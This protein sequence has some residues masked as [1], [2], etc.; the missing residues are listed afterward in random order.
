MTSSCRVRRALETA[1]AGRGSYPRWCS[2]PGGLHLRPSWWY[3]SRQQL[4]A[5]GPGF[6][7]GLVPVRSP[8]RKESY[9]VSFPPL[10]YM[11]KFS[12][13]ADL[14]SCLR[15][16]EANYIGG[17]LQA[18]RT[19][20]SGNGGRNNSNNCRNGNKNKSKN[21]GSTTA[22]TATATATTQTTTTTT[23]TA[24]TTTAA[25]TQQKQQLQR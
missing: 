8:L 9:L 6:H 24:T 20:D 21:D 5:T 22:A 13:F 10:T 1:D 23:T 14:T 7:A 17:S 19:T 18:Q 3:V 25:T 4:K 11:F 12:G 16:Y 15:M 2:F